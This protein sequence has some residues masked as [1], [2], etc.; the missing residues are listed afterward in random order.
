MGSVCMAAVSRPAVRASSV[1]SPIPAAATI[2][3][4]TCRPLVG[5]AH[6]RAALD[7]ARRGAARAAPAGSSLLEGEPGIGKSRL[8]ATSPGRPAR[9][10]PTCS[11]ARASE[12]EADL[13]YALLRRA[14]ATCARRAGGGWARR[15]GARRR[16][17]ARGDRHRDRHRCTGLC[18]TCSR[19][20]AAA[21]PLV[22]CARRRAL[23][24][25]RVRGRARRARAPAAG[26]RPSC[27]RSPP[28]T[29]PAAASGSRRRSPARCARH[30]RSR[31]RSRR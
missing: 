11:A 12:F 17:R 29:G 8:L 5:R 26:R 31:S 24:R 25:S 14:D 30:A 21:R 1:R 15:P 27:S 16:S 2:A 4:W 23:G 22:L 13:P 7:A 9:R 28:A 3:P 18:A 20:C 6:E 10:A 19:A